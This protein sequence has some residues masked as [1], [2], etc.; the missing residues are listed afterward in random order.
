MKIKGLDRGVNDNVGARAVVFHSDRKMRYPWSNGCFATPED[1]NRRIIDRT[2][3]GVLVC[4][5]D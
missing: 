2:Q 5:I 1:V 3:G 4:V